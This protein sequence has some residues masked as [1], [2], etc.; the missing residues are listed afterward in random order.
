MLKL[1]VLYHQLREYLFYDDYKKRKDTLETKKCR[2]CPN[3]V[4]LHWH[5]CPWCKHSDFSFNEEC[6][7]DEGRPDK[8][9]INRA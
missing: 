1:I 8:S 2:N 5:M 9:K 4:S 3:R 7:Y 6:L